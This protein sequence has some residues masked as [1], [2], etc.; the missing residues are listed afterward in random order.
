[1]CQKSQYE[2][3]PFQQW[4]MAFIYAFASTFNPQ[5]EIEPS[6]YPLPEF[7][8]Q[9]LEEEIQKEESEL[10]HKIICASLGNALNRK[11]YVESFKNSLHQIVAD[12]IKSF[13]IDL[14]VNPLNKQNFNSLSIELKLYI[15]HSLIEWQLQDSRAIKSIIDHNNQHTTKN[16]SNPIRS[17]PIGI[18]SKKRKYWQFGESCWIWRE[19]ANMKERNQWEIVCRNRQELEE[20]VSSLSSSSNKSEKALVKVI[21]DDIY[22]IAD[23]ERQKRLRKE[24][25][26]MRKLIP[27]EISI[28]PTQLRSRGDRNNR[29]RY[30]YDDVYELV[31]EDEDEDEDEYY[32]EDNKRRTTEDICKPLQAPIRWSSRLNSNRQQHMNDNN[33]D[34]VIS[35]GVSQD[36]TL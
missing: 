22:E 13:E 28:T 2:F 18:D 33:T 24:R 6:F 12:K 4:E 1:M 9:D 35:E 36:L 16:Q 32:E 21:Q 10:I 26:E 23:K 3:T 31:D 15:L 25:A 19:K 17:S 5:K 29:V 20:F 11:N 34:L 30:N 27:V 7:T 14:E 8:P